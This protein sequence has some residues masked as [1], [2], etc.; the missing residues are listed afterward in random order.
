MDPFTSRLLDIHSKMLELDKKEVSIYQ[1]EMW[2][3][4]LDLW[5]NSFVFVPYKLANFPLDCVILIL[6]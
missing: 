5:R 4:F 1:E 3:T 2:H 6:V